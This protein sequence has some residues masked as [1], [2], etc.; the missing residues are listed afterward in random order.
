MF[1]VM[2][3]TFVSSVVRAVPLAVSSTVGS[4]HFRT[5]SYSSGVKSLLLN[6]CIDAIESSAICVCALCTVEVEATPVPFMCLLRTC[7]WYVHTFLELCTNSC[8]MSMSLFF[9]I[10]QSKESILDLFLRTWVPSDFD[11]S[12]L[13]F[14]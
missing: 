3:F 8:A 1:K 4:S 2:T 12:V 10:L 7:A 11:H 9:L 13:L 14:V 6:M 5:A